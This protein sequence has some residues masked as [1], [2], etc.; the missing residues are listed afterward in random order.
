MCGKCLPG[1][2]CEAVWP[3]RTAVLAGV[4]VLAVFVVSAAPSF[5]RY[6]FTGEG[7][8]GLNGVD[9]APNWTLDRVSAVSDAIDQLAAPND[10]IASFWPGYAFASRSEPYPGFENNFGRFIS[11]K[12]TVDQREKYRVIAEPDVEAIFAA[13]RPRIVV[14]GKDPFLGVQSICDDPSNRSGCVKMLHSDGYS[15]ARA[16]GDT[17]VFVWGVAPP[18]AERPSAVN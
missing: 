7:V 5:R 1:I 11:Q 2:R 8:M 13:H 17:S 15:L 16:I 9:D 18:A 12:L 14:L 6:L 3:R 4:A 10:E